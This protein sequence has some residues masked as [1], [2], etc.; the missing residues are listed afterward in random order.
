VADAEITISS[1]AEAWAVLDR[2]L[3]GEYDSAT[4]I[5]FNLKGWPNLVIDLKVGDSAITPAM[6]QGFLALQDAVYRGYALL[7]HESRLKN[8]LTDD[9]KDALQ[10]IVIVSKGSSK[11]NINPENILK[12]ILTIL[13]DKLEPKHWIVIVTVIALSYFG[14]SAYR[15]Y[16]DHQLEARKASISSEEKKA[17]LDGIKFLS[18]QE[19]ERTKLLSQAIG[20]ARFAVDVLKHDLADNLGVQLLDHH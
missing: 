3:K 19:T 13:K 1:E 14:E 5:S 2:A 4:D 20:Q 11:Y 8:V 12:N 15:A 7:A 16:L 18:E 6:M 9:E 10:I 17:W